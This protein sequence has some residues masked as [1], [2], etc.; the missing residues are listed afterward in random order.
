[1]ATQV[2]YSAVAN[3]L[4]ADA[5]TQLNNLLAG[6]NPFEAGMI[7]NYLTPARIN[8]AAGEASKVAVDTLDALRSEKQA[9]AMSLHAA[10]AKK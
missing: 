1:M 3:A 6:L 5:N 2:E 9:H 7:R 8:A 4:V 10:L